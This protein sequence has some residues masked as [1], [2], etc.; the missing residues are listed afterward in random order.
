MNF[1][2]G[3]TKRSIEVTFVRTFSL[4]TIFVLPFIAALSTYDMIKLPFS[5]PWNI[6]GAQATIQYNP[7]NDIFRFVFI[8]VL[9]SIVLIVFCLNRAVRG[10]LVANV[11]PINQI[12]TSGNRRRLLKYSVYALAI[13]GL[14]L[15]AGAYTYRSSP[16]DT[17]HE[18][19]SLGPAV[20]YLH[21]KVPYKDIVFIHGPFRDPLQAVL[22]F[23][24]F[25]KSIAA[26]R[27]LTSLISILSLVL[28]FFVIYLLYSKNIYYATLGLYSF[29][30]IAYLRPLEVTF[31]VGSISLLA[32][33]IVAALLQ[34]SM[35]R[36]QRGNSQAK[37]HILLFLF[38]FFPTL[39]FADSIDRAC[40]LFTAATIHSA[41][42]FVL[43][44][45]GLYAKSIFSLLAGYASGALVFGFVI[46]WAYWDFGAYVTN[47][48]KFEPLMNGFVY[49]F[50]DFQFL[51][52]VLVVSVI[53][54]WLTH[55]FVTCTVL[56]KGSFLEKVK[57]FY[58]NHFL[59]LFLLTVSIF[60]F[61]RALIRSDSA[62]VASS[63][64][65]IVILAMY[66]FLK[67]YVSPVLRR[68]G[69]EDVIVSAASFAVLFL[70]TVTFTQG[71]SWKRWY[72]FPLGLPEE[73][74]IPNKYHPTISFLK[75]N[76]NADEDFLTLTSE[77]SWYYFLD[78]PCPIRFPVIYHAMPPFYQ[79]E[80]VTDLQKSNV[81]FILYKNNH[82]ANSIEGYDNDVRLP[83]VMQY[84]HR[85]YSFLKKFDDN[86]IWIRKGLDVEGRQSHINGQTFPVQAKA[87]IAPV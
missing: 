34:A 81:K 85:N 5:N 53:L 59:E 26:F 52:P 43:Y 61:R 87:G 33:L 46:S 24:L 7:A 83:I 75:N 20:D 80:I 78:K 9:P 56:R 14:I 54:Y 82:W 55:R 21:G 3:M 50:K 73:A 64:H 28:F 10:F 45:R 79:N 74:F 39:S 19:E 47:L 37:L 11:F 84:I 66:I 49:P 57:L 68:T 41:I 13:S 15:K 32:L 58:I 12:R 27:T 29:I 62:H 6:K 25:G 48:M 40:Y 2:D 8:V 35:Q 60:Y 71:I 18:G 38:V 72:R 36:C 30:I 65:P 31:N 63:L 77:A 69:R 23:K 4:L 1:N 86:E 76:L 17:F 70:F 44:L 16:L 67:H 42:I 51:A 22:A